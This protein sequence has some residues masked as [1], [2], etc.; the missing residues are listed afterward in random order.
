VYALFLLTTTVLV[1]GSAAAAPFDVSGHD[2]EGT[3]EFVA[4]AKAELGA[5]RVVPTG[6]LEMRDLKREDS[7][8]ILHPEKTLDVE[9]LARFMRVGGRVIMLDDYG[10]GE[11]LLAHFS[12]ERV[13]VPRHPAEALRN[14]PS[15]AIAEPAS[16]HPV[17]ADVV[18][19]VTNHA[20]GLRHPDLSPVLKI[21]GTGEP[22]VL[23]AVAGAVGQGRL[24][25]VGDPS[26]VMNA[27]LRYPGNKALAR[28]IIKYAADDDTWGKRTSGKLYIVAGAFTQR[29]AFGEESILGDDWAE[30]LRNLEDAIAQI[31]T[32]GFSPT[33]SY[34]LAVLLGLGVVLW[35]GSRAARTHRPVV[36]RF[37]REVPLVA[38]GGVAGHAAVIGAPHTS[39]VL[40][41]LELKSALEDDLCAILGLDK[42]PGHEPLMAQLSQ[43][44]LLDTDA[45][46]TLKRLLLRLSSIETMVLSQ[47]HQP[48][49]AGT[50][51][52]IRAVRDTEVLHAARAIKKILRTCHGRAEMAKNVEKVVQQQGGA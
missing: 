24:L 29:G 12:L 49:G 18:K 31:R 6:Q 34:I 52:P 22:D 4:L 9:S 5:A 8:V 38:Q 50:P 45:L 30:R 39:R 17:A 33:L 48:Q 32:G 2:W 14:N 25:V 44:S 19:V 47:R 36:P 1:S 43:R 10:S 40:A 11:A 28:G 41:M 7:I 26:T 42:M 46:R 37:T 51:P 16:A 20:T 13:P 35:V 21:R 15:F 3:A 27:M 23:V